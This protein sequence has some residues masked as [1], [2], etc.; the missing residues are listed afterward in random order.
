[1]RI[2]H[3]VL[4]IVAALP[5]SA[6]AAPTAVFPAVFINSS[7][8]PTSPAETERLK[9]MDAALTKALAESGQYQP[10]DLAPIAADF[11]AVRDIHDCNGCELDLAKK[12][13]A[14]YAV[15]AW[16]QKVSNLILNL[17]IRIEDV[18]TGQVVKA[19]S[20]DIRGN[21]DESWSR[22]LRYLLKEYVLRA[23]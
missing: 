22:G 17:N 11:S 9:T 4:A 5:L 6:Q 12:A 16:A 1:M 14:K 21:T 20:A 8:E 18:E 15:V 7:P 13:G 19:G 23:R 10:V 3:A 2:S